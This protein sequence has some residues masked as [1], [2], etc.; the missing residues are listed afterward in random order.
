MIATHE[1]MTAAVSVHSRSDLDRLNTGNVRPGILLLLNVLH[2]YP[3]QILSLVSDRHY[4]LLYAARVR[5][6]KKGTCSP[7]AKSGLIYS[8]SA[9]V[10][11]T[12]RPKTK[13]PE[14]SS[15]LDLH[16]KTQTC[17]YEPKIAPSLDM[18]AGHDHDLART[19]LMKPSDAFS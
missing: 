8:D 16:Q 3:P 7:V 5:R 4:P 11:S 6:K 18:H 10:V 14:V 9:N 19:C 13:R 1:H 2:P 17:W 12:D 15:F